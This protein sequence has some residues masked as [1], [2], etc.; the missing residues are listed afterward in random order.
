MT[1]CCSLISSMP[2]QGKI[3]I[4][5]N[6]SILE[7]YI[8]VT[9]GLGTNII[10]NSYS[11]ES[12]NTNQREIV[13]NCDHSMQYVMVTGGQI[14]E[15]FTKIVCIVYKCI[16]IYKMLILNTIRHTFWDLHVAPGCKLT[17][18]ED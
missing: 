11:N 8:A 9:D 5:I 17:K 4:S 18:N 6:R 16:Y 3:R 2:L 13:T 14:C 1:S 7:Y 12:L 10:I 15:S